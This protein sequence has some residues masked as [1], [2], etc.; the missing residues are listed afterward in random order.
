VFALLPAESAALGVQLVGL[1]Q[2]SLL[3][4]DKAVLALQGSFC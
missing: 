4:A 2:H 1:C 3:A